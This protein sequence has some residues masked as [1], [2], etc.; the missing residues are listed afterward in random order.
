MWHRRMKQKKMPKT[1]YLFNQ[2]LPFWVDPAQVFTELFAKQDYSFWLDSSMPAKNLARFSFIGAIGMDTS[3]K[4]ALSSTLSRLIDYS[5]HKQQVRCQY[6]HQPAKHSPGCHN[7]KQQNIFDFLQR[8]LAETEHQVLGDPLPFAFDCGFVGYLGYELKGDLTGNR[9]HQNPL[10]DACFIQ[11]DRAIVFDHLKHQVYLLCLLA[12]PEQTTA[13]SWFKQMRHRLDLLAQTPQPKRQLG[14]HKL[15]PG[16]NKSI[17]EDLTQTKANY[18]QDIHTCQQKIRAGE[19]YEICLTNRLRSETH[20]EPLDYYLRLRQ[21]NPTPYAAF[22]RFANTAIACFS[23]ERFLQISQQKNGKYRAESKPIKGT[24]RRDSH[25]DED[26]YLRNQLKHS[27]KDRAEN[28]MIVDL[29]RNDLG[30]VCTPGSVRVDK[31]MAIETYAKVH[32]MVSTIS[33]VLKSEQDSIDCIK[34]LFPAGS[35]T[36]APKIRTMEIV[37]QLESGARGV[38]AGALGYIGFNGMVDLNVVIRTAVFQKYNQQ[39]HQQPHKP[40][41]VSINSGGAITVLS[42][43]KQ[44]FDELILKISALWKGLYT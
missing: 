10:P 7:T 31:L 32:H 19:S 36:G 29:V 33:G 24:I 39:P 44:E 8:A 15:A 5:V 6:L 37:D 20:T 42:D 21:E 12:E 1:L 25:P 41:Q 18:L 11:T 13:T 27:T 9:A 38:Y 22:F 28:L 26:Q 4:I 40:Y 23:P 16:H 14:I 17:A 34:A 30:M 2:K 35:M 43:A 3:S